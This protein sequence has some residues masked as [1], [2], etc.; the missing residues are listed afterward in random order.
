VYVCVC[1]S[2]IGSSVSPLS[3][4]LARST[5]VR[6]SPVATSVPVSRDVSYVSHP[7]CRP[8]TRRHDPSRAAPPPPALITPYLSEMTRRRAPDRVAPRHVSFGSLLTPKSTKP[9]RNISFRSPCLRIH[10][11]APANHVPSVW[12]AART[13]PA[14]RSPRCTP[15][16][17][18][19][20]SYPVRQSVTQSLVLTRT[21]A[22]S[23]SVASSCARLLTQVGFAALTASRAAPAFGAQLPRKTLP[24]RGQNL[25]QQWRAVAV[26]TP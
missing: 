20:V 18:T 19:S 15:K 16:P 3:L 2:S 9:S 21:R 17:I 6:C 22:A 8:R 11:S 10:G 23:A 26:T 14:P 24:V 4:S 5:D 13:P 1:R 12:P 7:S 25:T